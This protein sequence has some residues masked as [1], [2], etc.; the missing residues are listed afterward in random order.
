[1]NINT[2]T[3]S[4]VFLDALTEQVPQLLHNSTVF[5]SPSFDLIMWASLSFNVLVITVTTVFLVKRLIGC[6][7]GTKHGQS[8]PN[9]SK[10]QVERERAET[11][12]QAFPNGWFRICN[13]NQVS[14]G[15]S[16]LFNY[17][18]REI[19]VFRGKSGKIGVLDAHCPHLGANLGIEGSVVND[20][21]QCPFHLWEFGT[22]GECTSIP[23]CE[24][25][26]A[27]SSIYSWPTVERYGMVMVWYHSNRESPDYDAIQIPELDGDK[28]IAG[29]SYIYEN[30]KMNI[31]DFAE[32]SAD[33]QHFAPLHGKMLLPWSGPRSIFGRSIHVPFVEIIHKADFLLS[34]DEKHVAYFT[35]SACLSVFGRKITSTT[36]NAKITF[37]GPCGITLFQFDGSFGKIYLFHTHTPTSATSLDVGFLVFSERKISSLLVWYIVGNWIAQWQNDILV[38]ENKI[39]RNKPLLVKV[40]FCSKVFCVNGNTHD[41]VQ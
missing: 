26:P 32:N 29:S 15:A 11:F 38:W 23:Y 40:S 41:H 28:F 13:S 14:R 12:P 31:Q 24:K 8:K 1:M 35:N 7:F 20:C 22:N 6:W 30:V 4:S 2:K 25:V 5:L 10:L 17:F 19:V 36:V 9:P 27:N 39:Y 16:Q 33:V 18:G 37:Y 34:N 3:D 21:I